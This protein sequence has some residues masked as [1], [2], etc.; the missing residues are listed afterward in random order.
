MSPPPMSR[1]AAAELAKRLEHEPTIQSA[2]E[3]RLIIAALR[4]YAHSRG[5][6]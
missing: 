6:Q 5:S 4:F 3:V 1:T 2:E